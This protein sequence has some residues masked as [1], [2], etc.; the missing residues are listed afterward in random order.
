MAILSSRHQL[1][2]VRIFRYTAEVALALEAMLLLH[3]A[4]ASHSAKQ[5]TH[6]CK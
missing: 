2:R 3:I 1:A 4:A 6:A 5:P